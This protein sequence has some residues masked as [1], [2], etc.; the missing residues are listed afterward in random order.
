[1]TASCSPA[2]ALE[3]MTVVSFCHPR[4]AP[5]WHD[6]PAAAKAASQVWADLF[7]HQNLQLNDLVA[8][9]KKRA[10]E[11]PDIAPEPG[12][13]IVFARAVRRDREDR[14]MC[15]PTVR[16]GREAAIDAKARAAI[17]PAAAKFGQLERPASR[18]LPA[19]RRGR[20]DPGKRAE[21][22]AEL[23]SKR[24]ATSA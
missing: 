16:A 19:S 6:D 9:V 7:S 18:A 23:A 8:G 5:R 13:I 3:V 22:E 2:D 21:V 4:T 1:M 20:M 12:E 24:G 15:D 14:A 10:S 17:G 11:S